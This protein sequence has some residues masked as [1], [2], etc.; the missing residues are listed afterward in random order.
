M[1]QAAEEMCVNIEAKNECSIMLCNGLLGNSYKM[2]IRKGKQII[3]QFV[4]MYISESGS[5]EYK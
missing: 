5:G 2:L 3:H 4:E 1:Y